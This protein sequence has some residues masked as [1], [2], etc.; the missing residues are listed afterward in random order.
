MNFQTNSQI[1]DEK[2]IKWNISCVIKNSLLSKV[3]VNIPVIFNIFSFSPEKDSPF[4]RMNYLIL[5]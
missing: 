5:I 3:I 2:D 1:I 4:F